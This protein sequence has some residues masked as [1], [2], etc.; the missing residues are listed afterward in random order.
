MDTPEEPLTDHEFEALADFRFEIRRFLAFS[1]TNARAAGLTV[2]QH[3]ALLA[4]R[5]ELGTPSIGTVA[6]RLLIE[7]HS[8]S[9]LVKRLEGRGLVLRERDPHDRRRVTLQL[10]YEAQEILSRLSA[11]HRA[12]IR[13]MQP[14]LSR[15]LNR[16]VRRSD[17]RGESAL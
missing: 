16:L 6:E 17:R 13:R 1:E 15:L 11:I 7:H 10:T 4:V 9:E 2:Q 12:E 5:G 8:A 3:Q 14:T